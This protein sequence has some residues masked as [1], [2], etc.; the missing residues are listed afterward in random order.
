MTHA[1]LYG[2][3][4]L[5]MDLALGKVSSS[6]F[7]GKQRSVEV[8]CR[9]ESCLSGNLSHA[10]RRGSQGH[11]NRPPLPAAPPHGSP[12][13]ISPSRSFRVRCS[14]GPRCKASSPS[15]TVPPKKKWRLLKQMDPSDYIEPEADADA[16]WRQN[17][18]TLAE[19]A[20][21]VIEVMEDQ[22]SRGQVLKLTEQDARQRFP[23]LTIA[24]LGAN[25]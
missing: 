2:P 7:P 13:P 4:R 12:G 8:R 11:S 24:S 21:K 19:H 17:Y 16:V 22:A 6:V 9:L 23:N 15:C 25:R 14:C 18:S 5:L 10:F 1:D 3:P 20:D